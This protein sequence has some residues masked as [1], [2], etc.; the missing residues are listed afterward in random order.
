MIVSLLSIIKT[1]PYDLYIH[2]QW[3]TVSDLDQKVISDLIVLLLSIEFWSIMTQYC[4]IN[5]KQYQR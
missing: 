3:R 2:N 1:G 5:G 4:V